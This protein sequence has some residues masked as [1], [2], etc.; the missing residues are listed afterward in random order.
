MPSAPPD[1]GSS[2][3][4]RAVNPGMSTGR[5]E[6]LT[7]RTLGPPAPYSTCARVSGK[8]G[9][10]KASDHPLT[11]DVVLTAPVWAEPI[12]ASAAAAV[13]TILTAGR[14]VYE[15]VEV[16][17]VSP[18]PNSAAGA[19]VR[20]CKRI[21][22]FRSQPCLPT[23]SALLSAAGFGGPT[24]WLECGISRRATMITALVSVASCVAVAA[25][26]A[27]IDADRAPSKEEATA[28]RA[29][30]YAHVRCC[31]DVPVERVAITR[32]RIAARD[33]RYARADLISPGLNPLVVVLRANGNR[34]KVLSRGSADVGCG[35]ARKVRVDLRLRCRGRLP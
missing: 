31:I 7:I 6:P 21:Q 19:S 20:G 14:H 26:A 30:V 3:S 24:L 9:A 15:V 29:A 5:S 11:T 18:A 28:I 33:K 34:W 17:T 25:A 2:N 23:R 22:S 32:L 16:S 4:A 12:P 35:L 27:A 1:P 8:Y 10:N 13:E